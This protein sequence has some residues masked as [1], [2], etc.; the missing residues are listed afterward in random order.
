MPEKAL[1]NTECMTE[2]ETALQ[3]TYA[4]W[5][6]RPTWTESHRSGQDEKRQK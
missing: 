1:E 4:E 3:G 2:Y 6:P 5:E